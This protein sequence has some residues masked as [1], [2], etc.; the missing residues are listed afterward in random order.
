MADKDLVTVTN[1]ENPPINLEIMAY[2][3]IV[4]VN[5]L[6]SIESVVSAHN[7]SEDSHIN[8]KAEVALKANIID[9]NTSL[10]TKADISTT[11][12]ISETD[13]LLAAKINTSDA[14]VTKQGNTFNGANQLVRL[15]SSGQLP[16]LNGSLVTG[17]AN[18]ML[19]NIYVLGALNNLGF[20]GQSLIANGYYKLPNSLV[21]QWGNG[22]V[23]QN[24]CATIAFPI[25][26]PNA[27]LVSPIV[28]ETGSTNS[29]SSKKVYSKTASNFVIYNWCTETNFSYVTLGY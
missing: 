9:M 11:Y 24:T 26:F 6:Q 25:T 7:I 4:D 21:L 17:L 10:A 28:T 3:N 12:T 29:Y 5:F 16:S 2:K 18:T 19:S 22:T 20:T 15:N 8:I 23:A 1:N 13:T 14:T 27:C